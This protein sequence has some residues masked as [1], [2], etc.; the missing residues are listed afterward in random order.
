MIRTIVVVLA[1]SLLL[2]G[3]ATLTIATVGGLLAAGA[4]T[5]AGRFAGERVAR[6]AYTRHVAW[7]HCR[8]YTGAT[9]QA[10]VEDRVGR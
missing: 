4:V 10:C 3:C 1:A 7:K 6:G 9:R 5:G 8:M 2:Q